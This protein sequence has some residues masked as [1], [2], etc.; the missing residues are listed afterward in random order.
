M[1]LLA[2]PEKETLRD[3]FDHIAFRYDR[4]NTLLSLGIDECW[5]EKAVDLILKGRGENEIILD[6]G[7]GTGKFLNRFLKKK[8]W[9]LAVGV[10]FS[11]A[12]LRRARVSLP[13]PCQLLHADI[14][15]LPFER[16]SFDLVVSS[17]TLRSVKDRAHF[18]E[19]VHRILKPKGK[20]AFLCLTRPSSFLG[21]MLYA[22]YL[23][24][25]LPFM[26]GVLT[27]DPIAYRFL[28]ESIQSFPAPLEI[29]SELQTF[30]FQQ[31]ST[32]SFTLGISTLILGQK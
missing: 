5:R 16:Q 29:A 31:I 1:S 13:V 27:S 17:F 25:Y 28:S 24:F 10:D 15:D 32:F 14:H 12:M 22:P 8:P 2:S 19:E 11:S 23:R 9:R 21:R 26:G 4:I 6:L 7:V 3:I 30:G 18:F 20:V